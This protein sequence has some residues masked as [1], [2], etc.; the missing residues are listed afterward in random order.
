MNTLADARWRPTR[1]W[2]LEAR[3]EFLRV[4]RTPSFAV[5]TLLFPPLFYLPPSIFK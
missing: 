2:W 3:C 4:L 5:P 1:A